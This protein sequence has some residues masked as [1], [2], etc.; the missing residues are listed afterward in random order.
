MS[1]L[2]MLKSLGEEYLV[3][4]VKQIEKYLDSHRNVNLKVEV[5]DDGLR[6]FD[7]EVLL[8]NIRV[9]I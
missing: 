6:V 5:S 8:L 2:L 1:Q 9:A 3:R 7:S 4:S